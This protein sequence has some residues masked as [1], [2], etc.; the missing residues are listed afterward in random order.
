MTKAAQSTSAAAKFFGLRA[1]GDPLRWT[2]PVSFDVC[3]ATGTLHGGCALGAAVAS[4]ELSTD[5]PLAAASGQYLARADHGSTVDIELEI[6]AA[7][8]AVTQAAFKLTQDGRVIV[9]GHASLGGRDLGIDQSWLTMPDVPPPDE[10]PSRAKTSVTE[11]SFSDL[12]DLRVAEHR[13][14]DS[15]MRYW[16]RLSDGLATSAPLLTALA[17]LL[18]SGM[19]VGINRAFRGSS[20]DNS[21]RIA[22]DAV[23]EWVLIDLQTRAFHNSIGH[24]TASVFAQSGELLATG[25]QCFAVTRLT[26]PLDR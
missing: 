13:P 5:R 10:C 22:S 8:K 1:T 24:G 9:H 6:L 23:S 17:D 7:G 2:L 12:A 25:A 16:G 15:T 3:G 11:H 20:L 21:I 14:G 26:G 18:P 19:R 4:L